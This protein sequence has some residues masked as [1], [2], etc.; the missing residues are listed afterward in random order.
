MSGPVTE[1]RCPACKS[2]ELRETIERDTFPFGEERVEISANIPVNKCDNCGF[3]FTDQRAEQARHAAICAQ[4]GLLAPSEIS[5][6]RKNVLQMSRDEFHSAFGLSSASVERWENGK[7]FQNEAADT[8][9]RALKDPATARR[10]DRRAVREASLDTRVTKENVIWGCFPSLASS[11][12]K[13]DEA[14]KMSR[15]FDLRLQ[16]R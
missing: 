12:E 14:M 13:A 16:A 7:L 1:A 8:L 6:I 3:V 4:R 9:L 5:N 15:E 10:L 2:T 11:R